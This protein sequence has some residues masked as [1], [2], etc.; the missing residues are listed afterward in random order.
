MAGNFT[1]YGADEAKVQADLAALQKLLAQ[2]A[3]RKP[4]AVAGGRCND[5]RR[6]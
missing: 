6:G 3:A 5:E 4:D 1:A 2:Q